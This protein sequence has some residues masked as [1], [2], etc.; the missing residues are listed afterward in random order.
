MSASHH[1]KGRV[2][3][4]SWVAMHE[5]PSCV[6]PLLQAD[7]SSKFSEVRGLGQEPPLQTN[8]V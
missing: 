8:Q 2:M 7:K 1:N 5:R 6:K 3:E 4:S